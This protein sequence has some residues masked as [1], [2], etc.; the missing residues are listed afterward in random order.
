[1]SYTP[2]PPTGS[3]PSRRRPSIIKSNTKTP[4]R[5]RDNIIKAR[6][7][8]RINKQKGV[9]VGL[10]QVL[11]SCPAESPDPTKNLR[12]TIIMEEIEKV[13]NDINKLENAG[14]AKTIRIRRGAK[15]KRR[16]TNR[17]KEKT[18]KTNR[19]KEKTRK[20]KK[21]GKKN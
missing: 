21:N 14:Q 17:R 1:M 6:N 15:A 4:N 9:L 20:T 7:L 12:R 3:T 2:R 10:K 18:R 8:D 5:T 11:D 19:R 16:K 13:E